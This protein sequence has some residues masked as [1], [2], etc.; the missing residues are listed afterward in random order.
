VAHAFRRTGALSRFPENGEVFKAAHWDEA[1][2]ILQE[3]FITP[4]SY[5]VFKHGLLR[6]IDNGHSTVTPSYYAAALA[7]SYSQKE[8]FGNVSFADVIGGDWMTY[9]P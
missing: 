7:A 6:A 4:P 1:W 2:R 9:K 5:E 3:R 8:I